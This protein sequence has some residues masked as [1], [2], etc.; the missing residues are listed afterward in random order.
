LLYFEKD[1]LLNYK[2][3][4]K[5]IKQSIKKVLIAALCI[6]AII[7]A[8]VGCNS[9]DGEGNQGTGFEDGGRGD[10]AMAVGSGR[11][12]ETGRS[13]PEGMAMILD[14][15]LLDDGTIRLIDQLGVL[16]DSD[17]DGVTWNKS[18]I[19]YDLSGYDVGDLFSASITSN[20]SAFMSFERGYLH[21]SSTG[22]S[23][24][25]DI[26]LPELEAFGDFEMNNFLIEVT[27]TSNYQILGK[28]ALGTSIYLI[29]LSTG[30]VVNTFEQEEEWMPFLDFMELNGK[31]YALTIHGI[32]IYDLETGRFLEVDM[33]L[34]E[35]FSNSED[36]FVGFGMHNIRIFPGRE[37]NVIYIVE[38]SGLYRYTL[39]ASQLEQIINGALT[40]MSNS[41]YGFMA[42]LEK[43][44][45]S[46]LISFIGAAGQMLM[47]Y[48][49]D[50]DADIVPTEELVIF[51][52]FDQMTIRQAVSM[53]QSQNPH[54]LIQYEV[55]LPEDSPLTVS[56]AIVSLNTRIMAGDGPD[57]I[58][59]DDMPYQAYIENGILLELSEVVSQLK[60]DYEFFENI[61]MSHS[62]NGEVH[63]VPISFS[64]LAAAGP[65]D[66]LQNTLNLS[67]LADLVED[68]RDANEEIDTILGWLAP[69]ATIITLI[70]YLYPSLLQ[71][72][73]TIDENAL[74]Q[75]LEEVKRI[76][77]ANER[78]MYSRPE[79]GFSMGL[80][81]RATLEL[82]LAADAMTIMD[83]Q[84]ILSIGTINHF[85]SFDMVLSVND[86]ANWDYILRNEFVPLNIIGIN[87][88]SARISDSLEFLRFVFSLEVQSSPNFLGLP[89]NIGGIESRFD[90][91]GQ[92]T[93]SLGMSTS[94][95]NTFFLDLYGASVADLNR[96]IGEIRTLETASSINM[97]VFQVIHE[98]GTAFLEGSQSLDDTVGGILMRVNLFLAE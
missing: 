44:N 4:E 83:N 48:T 56:D 54:L 97:M 39:G 72:D 96:L 65:Q 41:A 3:N 13:L 22:E 31:L 51:S 36:S 89:V 82:P 7:V 19:Q 21:I 84:Q 35:H 87:A 95:G 43:E 93:G 53:F 58:F 32:D 25:L 1:L 5:M 92:A 74:R 15:V 38:R 34:Q 63:A 64:L 68:L 55:G 50:P 94:D 59:L 76:Y 70:H 73:G 6:T 47:D 78:D 28:S 26:D 91:A 18:G 23:N 80:T 60:N 88:G 29:E 20:G 85:F 14:I 8:T 69:K 71:D 98:E 61:L 30:E 11:F 12:I 46:F 77:D 57:I 17:D 90:G 2:E 49:F 67:D 42:V 16:Y 79:F 33:A 45:N 37:E 52:L 9:N 75:F 24:W 81:G 62:I 40:T 27:F 66:M 10:M 86:L